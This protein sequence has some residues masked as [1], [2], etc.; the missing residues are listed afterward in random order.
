MKVKRKGKEEL[1]I[2]AVKIRSCLSDGAETTVKTDGGP[3]TQSDIKEKDF[4][5]FLSSVLDSLFQL[6]L[7][8]SAVM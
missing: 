3:D 8:P 4:L 5:S 6:V 2:W 7:I 1:L